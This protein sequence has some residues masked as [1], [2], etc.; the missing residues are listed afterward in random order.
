MS[1]GKCLVAGVVGAFLLQDLAGSAQAAQGPKLVFEH[2]LS[3]SA[4]NLAISVD[5]VKLTLNKEEN[6]W[7]E[8]SVSTATRS[9]TAELKIEGRD[10]ATRNAVLGEHYFGSMNLK[11]EKKFMNPEA[12]IQFSR[13]FF[14]GIRNCVES[15]TM[16]DQDYCKIVAVAL[17]KETDVQAGAGLIEETSKKRTFYRVHSQNAKTNFTQF[18]LAPEG[19]NLSLID[20]Y[21]VFEL[22]IGKTG[23]E[24][25]IEQP[26][27]L[28]NFAA[29]KNHF[30][31][32]SAA[33]LNRDENLKARVQARLEKLE[34]LLLEIER[35][36]RPKDAFDEK[37]GEFLQ[38]FAAAGGDSLAIISPVEFFQL[39]KR[40]KRLEADL[41]I[42]AQALYPR[43]TNRDS[44]VTSYA[45]K[46]DSYARISGY[47][48]DTAGTAKV[49]YSKLTRFPFDSAPGPGPAPTPSPVPS[50]PEL[51]FIGKEF[52]GIDRHPGHDYWDDNIN[53]SNPYFACTL[54]YQQCQTFLISRP[55][56]IRER[57]A[58]SRTEF[59]KWKNSIE[60]YCILKIVGVVAP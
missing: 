53:D 41:V 2:P 21:Q 14:L 29:G 57:L 4:R 5:K 22:S 47:F 32:I 8:D 27:T 40:L 11:C 24:F 20:S 35:A 34:A 17:R 55:L 12:R 19:L 30:L 15:E 56:E 44:F 13:V 38:E 6:R 16:M 50:Q 39:E 23:R 28:S 36:A 9:C 1:F 42:L 33:D 58:C 3:L 26:N 45:A 59:K 18:G 54:A 31:S 48:G 60:K 7:Q 37:I 43:I 49:D 52:K 10:L 25:Y 46:F 51:E